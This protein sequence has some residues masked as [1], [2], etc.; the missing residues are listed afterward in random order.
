MKGLIKL[1]K[2]MMSLNKYERCTFQS[3]NAA[4]MFL[5]ISEGNRL[6][7]EM[8]RWHFHFILPIMP[9]KTAFM[10]ADCAA[11]V[12]SCYRGIRYIKHS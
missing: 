12:H 7:S 8:C 2:A 11:F 4:R 1:H 5:C 6:S 10:S 9:D 3:Q